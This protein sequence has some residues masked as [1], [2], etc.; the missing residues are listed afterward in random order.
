MEYN[1]NS[2]Q[3]KSYFEKASEELPVVSITEINQLI[4][5]IPAGIV[6]SSITNKTIQHLLAQY[7]YWLGG[8]LSVCTGAVLL[9]TNPANNNKNISAHTP[10][11]IERS[12]ENINLDMSNAAVTTNESNIVPAPVNNVKNKE[13]PPSEEVTAHN[14]PASEKSTKTPVSS[15]ASYYFPGA[16]NVNFELEGDHVNMTVGEKVEELE[17]NGARIDKSEYSKYEAIIDNGMKLK[18]EYDKSRS[19]E[20]DTANQQQ[21]RNREIMNG[22]IEQLK[23]DQLMDESGHFEF[24]ITGFK[25][26]IDKKEQNESVT[27]K[28]ISL[29]EKLSGNR[30]TINSNIR[31]EH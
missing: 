27:K 3:L 23:T 30:L 24:R 22:L 5:I 14:I 19:G 29:Y 17:I 25:L 7:K 26:F 31:I 4:S 16:A 10:V 6:A 20:S 2:V 28:Y 8:G 18:R 9:F 11:A 12:N 15:K 1:E 13:S 21:Q